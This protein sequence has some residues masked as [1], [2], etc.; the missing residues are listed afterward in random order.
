MDDGEAGIRLM[1]L[2]QALRATHSEEVR[3]AIKARIR[4]IVERTQ[5]VVERARIDG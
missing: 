5:H 1:Q 4:A 2:Y 3:R